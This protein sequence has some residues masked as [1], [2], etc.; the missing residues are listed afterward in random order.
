MADDGRLQ[1]G[2]LTFLP[3]GLTVLGA[4][5]GMF[6]VRYGTETGNPMIGIAIGAVLG[7]VAAG[8][9]LRFAE[10]QRGGL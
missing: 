1:G 8:L 7:R 9:I 3:Y 5:I 10:R 6:Y 4:A 2:F